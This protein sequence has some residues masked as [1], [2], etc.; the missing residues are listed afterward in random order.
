MAEPAEKNTHSYIS[1]TTLQTMEREK[2]DRM[3]PPSTNNHARV[4]LDM[5]DASEMLTKGSALHWEDCF[6]GQAAAFM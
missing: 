3:E 5:E 1:V 2:A 4:I 6:C